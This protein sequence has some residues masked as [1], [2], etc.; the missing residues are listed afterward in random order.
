LGIGVAGQPREQALAKAAIALM[1]DWNIAPTPDNYELFYVYAT[2]NNPALAKTIEAMVKANSAF[3]QS[4]LQD[5]S[6]RFLPHER[7]VQT[8]DEVGLGISGMIDAMLSKLEK[9][10]KDAGDY[11]RALSAASGELGG[12]Q[13][14]A[15]VAKLVDRLVGATQAMETRAKVLENELQRSS[16]QVTELKTQLDT[17]RKESRIDPLTSLANRK[18]F[19]LELKA[20]I[21]D[22]RETNTSVAL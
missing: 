13:S 20:A 16:E 6:A 2:G 9:A 10:G 1:A 18:A 4:V 3:T 7:T 22:A 17:V 8:M 21:E 5:L 11:G 19:D 14:P 15:A 12:N